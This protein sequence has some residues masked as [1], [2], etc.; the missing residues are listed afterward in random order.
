MTEPATDVN[1]ENHT[2][3][4]VENI[5]GLGIILVGTSNGVIALE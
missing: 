3:Y 4:W 5:S 1:T 2:I